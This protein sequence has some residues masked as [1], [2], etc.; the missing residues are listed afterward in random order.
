MLTRGS[1][2][3]STSSTA[4]ASPTVHL[5]RWLPLWN[6]NG[7]EVFF[8]DPEGKLTS[9]A[10]STEG[11]VLKVGAITSLFPLRL[12][13]SV[14][15]DAYPYAVTADGRQFLVNHFVDESTS[16]AITLVINWPSDR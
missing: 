14:R 13:P 10:V 1:E 15:L 5:I 3:S 2:G 11:G 16:G 12:R 6:R 4:R 9:A 8:I 7:K